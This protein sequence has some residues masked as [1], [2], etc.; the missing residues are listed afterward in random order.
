MAHT[1]TCAHTHKHTHPWG[2]AR[3][4]LVFSSA[5][6]T[7]R[8]PF[9]YVGEEASSPHTWIWHPLL[10]EFAAKPGQATW[11]SPLYSSMNLVSLR[12]PGKKPPRLPDRKGIGKRP[13]AAPSSV[14]LGARQRAR[15][16]AAVC[17]PD[18][19]LSAKPGLRS[20]QA[21]LPF[22]ISQSMLRF[23]SIESIQ[24]S[25]LSIP[26]PFALKLSQHQGLWLFPSNGQSTGA[27]ASVTV[28]PMNI[29]GCFPLG[30]TSL[31]SLLSKG[32]SR[33]FSS[34]TV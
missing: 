14:M 28:L 31:I 25:H 10:T 30:L 18:W 11:R 13:P 7:H 19:S 20:T 33:V 21:S 3:P 1:C 34:T 2:R 26:S 6:Q 15:A 22:T 17:G 16:R 9:N 8:W 4:S 23:M 12:R 32:L 29:R 5:T 27:S 24:L